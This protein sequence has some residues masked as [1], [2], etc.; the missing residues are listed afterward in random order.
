MTA[1]ALADILRSRAVQAWD[2]VP[3][4]NDF[5]DALP[6]RPEI[7]ASI[8]AG[9]RSVARGIVPPESREQWGGVA[10]ALVPDPM[11]IMRGSGQA[12]QAMMAGDPLGAGAGFAGMVLGATD[13]VPGGRAANVAARAFKR[14]DVGMKA[15]LEAGGRLTRSDPGSGPPVSA[16]IYPARGGERL[17]HYTESLQRHGIDV[18]DADVAR[19]RA[20]AQ[21]INAMRDRRQH[22]R[23][24]AS[25]TLG[26]GARRLAA[27]LAGR[28]Y[29]EEAMLRRAAEE[30]KRQSAISNIEEISALGLWRK[31]FADAAVRDAR[32]SDAGESIV[33][34]NLEAVPRHLA[35]EGWVL[36]HSSQ[37]PD[38]RKSSRYLVAPGGKYQVR[39]SDHYLP[40]TP[41]RAY[42]GDPSWNEEIV[43]SGGDR[44]DDVIKTIKDAYSE[45][46]MDVER[47]GGGI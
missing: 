46:L 17:K 2:A 40:D 41:E 33:K 22:D 18:P 29:N 39:L 9:V 47:A 44:P 43:L 42:R 31:D 34:A 38:R 16:A 21:E 30:A 24:G 11:A 5:Y 23:L 10:Q 14:G 36:R 12:G 26:G 25:D 4:K 8:K 32:I 37:G 1:K 15:A 19:V 3:E 28:R 7:P 6:E 45:W 20:D 35:K 27:I 13:L